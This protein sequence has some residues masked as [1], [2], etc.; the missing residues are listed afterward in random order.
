ME[1]NES[2][3]LELLDALPAEETTGAVCIFT[4]FTCGSTHTKA[5]S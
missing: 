5:A 3:V 2:D 1:N 4:I